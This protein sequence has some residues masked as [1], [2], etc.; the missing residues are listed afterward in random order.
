MKEGMKNYGAEG[1]NGVTVTWDNVQRGFDCCGVNSWE[2]WK[3]V[4]TTGLP[5]GQ[6][7]ESC[8]KVEEKGCGENPTA[9]SFYGK[10][11][12][13]TFSKHFTDTLNLVGGKT[14]FHLSLRLY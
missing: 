6:V 12:F 13:D 1:Y 10:G 3:N 5:S 2:E 4:T 9:E 8:C 11:C 7:P 14:T